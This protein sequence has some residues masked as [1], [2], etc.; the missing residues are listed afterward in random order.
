MEYELAIIGGGPAGVA[1]GIYASR[2]QLK[3]ILI[4]EEFGGQ[5]SV[6]ENIQNWVGTP[7]ISGAKLAESFT[8]HLHAYANDFVDITAGERVARISETKNGFEITTSNQKTITVKT[9]LI[10]S[11]GRRRKLEIPGAKEFEQKGLTYCASCDGP[12]FSGMDVVVIGGGNA[13]FETAAQLLAYAKSVSL[14]N[15]SNEFKADPQTVEQV[16]SN[17]IMRAVKNATPTAILGDKFVNAIRYTDQI[18]GTEKELPASGI[19]VEIGMIP[20]SDF[21]GDLVDL[22][23]YKRIVVNPKNQRSSKSGIWAAGDVTDALYH[24][25]NIAAGDGVK[26]LEDIYIYLKTGSHT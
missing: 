3:S 24:Q 10:A 4:T 9:V 20:N 1:A 2:K 19:F 25:N 14:L 17:P 21:L 6:S 7:S 18:S 11:G 22:D 15:R 13:G 5:S 23:Q 26:A 8:Q 16:L 12:L